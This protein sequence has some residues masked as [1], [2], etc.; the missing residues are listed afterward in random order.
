MAAEYA[1]DLAVE[2]MGITSECNSIARAV[3][4]IQQTGWRN[5]GIAVDM[6]HLVR[7]GGTPEE[8]AAIA[9]ELIKYAQ[10]CDGADTNISSDYIDEALYARMIPG[11]GCFPLVKLLETLP[12]TMALN[13]GVPRLASQQA[14]VSSLMRAQQSVTA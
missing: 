5:T 12:R 7:D 14:G 11:E 13:V 8:V 1:L 6:L 10:L 3:D 9:P 4:L 2:F